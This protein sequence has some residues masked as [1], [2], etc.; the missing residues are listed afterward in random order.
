M[1][2]HADIAVALALIAIG[3]G[4]WVLSKSQSMENTGLKTT[5]KFLGYL[6]TVAAVLTL[7]CTTY[8]SLKYW[9]DGAFK[10]A[11][12]GQMCTNHGGM[13]G[14]MMSG[15]QGMMGMMGGGCDKMM[16]G[17]RGKC[18][19]IGSGAMSGCSRM[20][21]KGDKSGHMKGMMP[22]GEKSMMK[23]KGNMMEDGPEDKDDE[24]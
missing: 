12:A 6:I 11:S 7:L 8:Y 1:I 14:G 13:M 23:M 4:F 22:G 18:Q 16:M 3:V 2:F 19:S 24:S 17:D 20:M 15:H 21:G 9:E 10:S 5:G